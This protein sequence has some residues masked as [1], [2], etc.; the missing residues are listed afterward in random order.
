LKESYCNTLV[1]VVSEI[2]L[3]FCYT[4]YAISSIP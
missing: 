3:L 1:H 2:I 4:T